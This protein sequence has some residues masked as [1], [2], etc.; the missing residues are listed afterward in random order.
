MEAIRQ[1]LA[2]VKKFMEPP[3]SFVWG[4]K[5]YEPDDPD[6]SDQ[7]NLKRELIALAKV[8]I[9]RAERAISNTST[10]DRQQFHDDLYDRIQSELSSD[11]EREDFMKFANT[12][13]ELISRADT[14]P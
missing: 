11:P 12:I 14:P 8:A 3:T 7:A 5:I 9:T 10:G 1:A 4:P 2:K 6:S 13:E